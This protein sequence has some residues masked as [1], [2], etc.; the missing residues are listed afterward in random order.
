LISCP[1]HLVQISDL[2]MPIF[3]GITEEIVDIVNKLEIA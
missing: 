1:R 3:R 2:L